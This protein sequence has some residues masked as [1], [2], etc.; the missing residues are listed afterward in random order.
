VILNSFLKKIF[1]FLSF[2]SIALLLVSCGGGGSDEKDD[3]T[4]VP[5]TAA[6]ASLGFDIKTFSFTWTDVS[7]ATF[8]RVMENPD[9]VSG[10]TQ[11]SGDIASGA[12]S[13][14]HEVALYQRINASYFL[15]SC[16]S[17]GCTDGDTISIT[18]TLTDAV[19]YFKASSGDSGD[20]F[21]LDVALSADGK[22]MAVGA[23]H[24]SSG[25]IGD[26]DDDTQASA[27]AA[28]VFTNSG[29]GWSQQAYIKADA[30][31]SGEFFGLVMCWPSVRRLR[32][33]GEFIFLLVAE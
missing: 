9:G 15:Q 18:G 16:N 31:M 30:P 10:F 27:G 8:Y 21:G 2:T 29:S 25:V 20:E 1:Y 24:E 11:V 3:S 14:N 28:Y 32:A 23:Q 17:A 19:G 26:E 22:T 7:D 4:T 6:T 5:G 13:F 12:Q 33:R